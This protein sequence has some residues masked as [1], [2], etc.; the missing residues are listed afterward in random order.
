[1]EQKAT[2]QL[3]LSSA[4]GLAAVSSTFTAKPQAET[5]DD[6]QQTLMYFNNTTKTI[7]LMT[8]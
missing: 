5:T 2:S 8:L 3:S 7:A 4:C 1:M 6:V